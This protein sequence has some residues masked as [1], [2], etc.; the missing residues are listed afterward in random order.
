MKKYNKIIHTFI[1]SHGI[2][3]SQILVDD[4]T[5]LYRLKFFLLYIVFLFIIFWVVALLGKD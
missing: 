3:F 4:G 5:F 1:L 2:I